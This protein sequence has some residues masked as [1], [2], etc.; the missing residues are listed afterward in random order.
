[1]QRVFLV[2]AAFSA[3]GFLATCILFALNPHLFYALDTASS[4]LARPFQT[5]SIVQ[6]FLVITVFGSAVGIVCGYMLFVFFSKAPVSLLVRFALIIGISALLALIFK[7]LFERIRPDGLMWLA[8][9]HSYSF[10]S[11]HATLSAA[12]YGFL[13]VVFYTKTRSPALRR[14]WIPLFIVVVALIGFSRLVLAV[15]YGSDVL[16]GFFLGAFCLSIGFLIP[17]TRAER[18]Y[19][20]A[21]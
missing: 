14:L 4:A 17:L 16:A 10:P 21:R 9:I 18:E 13:T 7:G 5:L 1:M 8:R 12:L 11:S 15:H 19:L 3:G 20:S 2:I 6:V